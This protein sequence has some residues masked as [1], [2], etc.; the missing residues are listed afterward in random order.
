MICPRCGKA[1]R[2]NQAFQVCSMPECRRNYHL[3]CS[4]ILEHPA[5]AMEPGRR[6]EIVVPAA[7]AGRDSR[8]ASEHSTERIVAHVIYGLYALNFFIVFTAPIGVIIAY[9]RRDSVA[10]HWLESHYN[11]QIR[12]F[13]YGLGLVVISWYLDRPLDGLAVYV[14]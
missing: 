8:T 9:V 4:C 7:R 10:G 14:I 6:N 1:I 2:D 11:W 13:W 12:S 3:G 5:S